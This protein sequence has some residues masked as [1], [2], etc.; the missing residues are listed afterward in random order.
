MILDDVAK[1]KDQDHLLAFVELSD[2]LE[3]SV[4][5]VSDTE[6]WLLTG[7]PSWGFRIT[8]IKKRSEADPQSVT[9][10]RSSIQGEHK[11]AIVAKE[12]GDG[13]M[14]GAGMQ[15]WRAKRYQLEQFED[16]T[17]KI[18]GIQDGISGLKVSVAYGNNSPPVQLVASGS[19]KKFDQQ[20][21]QSRQ[22]KITTALAFA[23]LVA[24]II[25]I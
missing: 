14:I 15:T 18:E 11:F 22:R 2:G 17:L 25:A 24:G 5:V 20:E 23:A 4:T 8:H 12:S 6:A 13:E 10:K 7:Y 3:A 1:I 16:A 9:I 21:T 19:D